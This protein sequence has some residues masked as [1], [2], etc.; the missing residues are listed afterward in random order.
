[1]EN[2][3][4][5]IPT[6][7]PILLD[8]FKYDIQYTHITGEVNLCVNRCGQEIESCDEIHFIN[9]T[10]N[11]KVMTLNPNPSKMSNS[12][13]MIRKAFDEDGESMNQYKFEKMFVM[14]P[15]YHKI[16]TVIY[17]AEF[18]MVFSKFDKFKKKKYMVLSVLANNRIDVDPKSLGSSGD[19][20][21]YKL[22]NELFG[23]PSKVPTLFSKKEINY[24]PN[25]V[26]LGDFI[27]PVGERSFYEYSYNY[28]SNVTY[29][30]F[31][32]PMVISA[33][34]LKNLQDKLTPDKL[35]QQFKQALSQYENPK[36]GLVIFFKQDTEKAAVAKK[37]GFEDGDDQSIKKRIEEVVKK[38]D[39]EEAEKKTENSE[40]YPTDFDDDGSE[41]KKGTGKREKEGFENSSGDEKIA[42]DAEYPADVDPDLEDGTPLSA[43]IQMTQSDYDRENDPDLM[44]AAAAEKEKETKKDAKGASTVDGD[45]K[46]KVMESAD[47]TSSTGEDKTSTEGKDSMVLLVISMMAIIFIIIFQVFLSVF[48]NNPEKDYRPDQVL[49]KYLVTKNEGSSFYYFASKIVIYLILAIVIIL[50]LSAVGLGTKYDYSNTR[51][52]SNKTFIQTIIAIGSLLIVM[53]VAIGINIFYRMKLSAKYYEKVSALDSFLNLDSIMLWLNAMRKGEGSVED[54]CLED[55]KDAFTL[56]ANS[57]IQVPGAIAQTAYVEN[58]ANNW[59]LNWTSMLSWSW[60][61]FVMII[62]FTV[63]I[64]IAFLLPLTGLSG[65]SMSHTLIRTTKGKLIGQSNAIVD[66]F[67]SVIYIMVI[68]SGVMIM[69]PQFSITNVT[70]SLEKVIPARGATG[71]VADDNDKYIAEQA[72]PINDMEML[73][74]YRERV[75]QIKEITGS[76][77][78]FYA[79]VILLV[80]SIIGIVISAVSGKAFKGLKNNRIKMGNQTIFSILIIVIVIAIGWMGTLWYKNKLPE[81][82]GHLDNINALI[83]RLTPGE[84]DQA[85]AVQRLAL[86]Q[87]VEA[88]QL[89]ALAAAALAPA[90]GT[91]QGAGQ[92]GAPLPNP[93]PQGQTNP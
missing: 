4:L 69:F 63:F 33:P 19:L 92:G 16:D 70:T 38:D 47:G 85:T 54:G 15:S 64:I 55:G 88:P 60:S 80:L 36:R 8:I 26:R 7:D 13:C 29:R 50:Y 43:L 90:Q 3:I 39:D 30:V 81:L 23:D 42:I 11:G 10:N 27:P 93:N 58:E 14:T 72:N 20:L 24:P 77:S 2:S 91:G 89:A 48:I 86:R 34:V 18:G 67:L 28:A 84:R 83:N 52:M 87:P 82:Q 65:F 73:E 35:Y 9:M 12:K 44:E 68:V 78:I 5:G 22:T 46:G 21:F 61:K 6:Q 71:G 57:E 53:L 40:V 41:G 32:R 74:T 31:Q 59:S 66:L 49:M 75:E 51:L 25:P 1:M 62:S 17:D 45:L 76:N 37:E 56:S 79:Y